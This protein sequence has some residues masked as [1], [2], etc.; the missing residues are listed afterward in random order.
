MR[1]HELFPPTEE[2][3]DPPDVHK[4]NVYRIEPTGKCVWPLGFV[5]AEEIPNVA[6]L[7]ER[8]GGGRYELVARDATKIVARATFQIAGESK[9]L[10]GR[11]A[12]P[13]SLPAFTMPTSSRS[14]SPSVLEIVAAL[15]PLILGYLQMQS[16]QQQ[17]TMA[18]ITGA[19]QSRGSDANAHV[20]SMQSMYQ[21]NTAQMTQLFTALASPK[22]GGDSAALLKGMEFVME[23]MGPAEESGGGESD[24]EINPIAMAKDV[25]DMLERGKRMADVVPAPPL[26]AVPAK[27]PRLVRQ[28]MPAPPPAEDDEAA[29]EGEEPEAAS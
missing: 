7:A 8:L 28:T 6:A 25:M 23:H 5:P 17:A 19:I 1:N 27:G 3:D 4:I 24:G 11:P 13:A 2:D 15:S 18:L 26:P 10:D 20:Q 29:G 16:Q 22:G 12:A 9:P 14:S 21:A